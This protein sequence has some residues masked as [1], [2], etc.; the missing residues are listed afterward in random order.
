MS[1][2]TLNDALGLV[3]LLQRKVRVQKN[4]ASRTFITN[5]QR[6]MA[7]ELQ[8]Q[9]PEEKIER[10]KFSTYQIIKWTPAHEAVVVGHIK[11]LTN[12]LIAA[13]LGISIAHVSNILTSVQGKAKLKEWFDKVRGE[14]E[15]SER[16]K[17]ER[18]NALGHKALE[19]VERFVDNKAAE[20]YDPFGYVDR[21]IKIAER[22]EY[23][24]SA[25]G[26]A[27][28]GGNTTNN[29]TQINILS[30]KTASK[31]FAALDKSIESGKIHGSSLQ[32]TEPGTNPSESVEG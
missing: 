5:A 8:Q 10:G 19:A 24:R 26:V 21:T 32:R 15:A 25:P 11:G 1:N 28:S 9:T 7:T 2:T 22:T 14:L 6:E 4:T 31:L 30:E 23:L 3:E 29:N 16:T 18:W 12:R 27:G 20:T 13:E 17:Q